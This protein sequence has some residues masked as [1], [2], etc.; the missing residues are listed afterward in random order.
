MDTNKF[1]SCRSCKSEDISSVFSLGN[2][3]LANRIIKKDQFNEEEPKYNLEIMLCRNC[4]LAQLKDIVSPEE[5]FDEYCYFSSYSDT[6]VGYAANLVEKLS[7]NLPSNANIVEIASNDGY[8]LQHYKKSFQ[9]LGIEPAKNIA[10]VAI[11]KGIS[12]RCEYFTKS[13]AETLTNEGIHADIIH[14]NNVM[15]HV[16]EINDFVSGIKK[17]LKPNGQAVIEVPYLLNLIKHCEFDTIYHEHVFYFSVSPLVQLFDRHHLVIKDIEEIPIHGGSIR[18]Y[19]THKDKAIMSQTVKDLLVHENKIGLNESSFFQKFVTQVSDLKEE[20]KKLLHTIKQQ[21]K[22][23]A[24]YGASAKGSTLLNFFD[25]GKDDIDFVVD[26]N[27]AKQGY[28]ISG[29]Q[30]PIYSTEVLLEKMPS[31]TLLLTWN[32]AEEILKQQSAYREQG[33]QFIIPIPTLMVI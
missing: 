30:I 24:A 6:L 17:L 8:L 28:Y 11:K 22:R 12:T 23:V 7:K 3:P 20:L 10:K 14:A 2:M 18:L 13:L 5:L 21:G 19:I 32:F 26:R 9:V 27:P 25:I 1:Q 31:F 15:A 29:T 16:P 4:G 33:G